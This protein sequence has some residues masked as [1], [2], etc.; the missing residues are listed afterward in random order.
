LLAIS[1]L[2]AEH[3]YREAMPTVPD[4]DFARIRQF[5]DRRVPAHLRDEAASKST[6]A[7]SQSPFRLSAALAGPS[8]AQAA[9]PGRCP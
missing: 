5:C 2:P 9:K 6:S 8:A 4:L 3:S 1:N 7:A